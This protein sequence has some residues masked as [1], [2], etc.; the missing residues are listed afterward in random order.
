MFIN[1]L[2]FVLCLSYAVG[3]LGRMIPQTVPLKRNFL[4]VPF[5]SHLCSICLPIFVLWLHWDRR[6][7]LFSLVSHCTCLP[8]LFLSAAKLISLASHLFLCCSWDGRISLAYPLSLTCS[9]F[10][11][12]FVSVSCLPFKCRRSLFEF[13]FF[14]TYHL[15][16]S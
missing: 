4:C 7:P 12:T 9:T 2:L 5:V 3:A 16:F 13:F 1:V 6:F 11:P 15:W 10:L 14:C 8:L